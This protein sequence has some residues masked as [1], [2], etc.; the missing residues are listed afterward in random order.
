MHI[1][2]TFAT[3]HDVRVLRELPNGPLQRHFFPPVRSGGRDGILVHVTPNRAVPWVGQF[4]FGDLGSQVSG[5]FSLP[6]PE[7]IAVVAKG[8]GYIVP[9]CRPADWSAIDIRP[10]RQVKVSRQLG[11]VLFSDWTRIA[12]YSSQ[13]LAWIS[14]RLC[15]DDLNVLT[16]ENATVKC[17]GHDPTDSLNPT[18]NVALDVRSGKV[19]STE[20][21]GLH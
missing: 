6:Q 7:H 10:V 4:A 8:A 20:F 13:G 15:W 14:E 17:S 16:I 1:D 3:D 18:K 9:I 12:A 21:R 11:F 19:V 2:N 5:V